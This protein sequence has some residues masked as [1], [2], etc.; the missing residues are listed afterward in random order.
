MVTNNPINLSQEGLAYYN[1]TGTFTGVDGSTT[2]FVCTSNGPGV[3]PT[4][5]SISAGA[6]IW[7]D[8][9]TSTNLVINSNY[10]ATA[11]VTL[12]L[13]ASPV[14]GSRIRVIVDTASSV[15]LQANTGQTIRLSS[16]TSTLAG[17]ITN[18]LRGD[19]VTLEYRSTGSVWIALSFI[20]AWTPA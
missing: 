15:V 5:Q 17:T 20:G 18:S 7:I 10:F 4:F 11:A 6:E 1:G 2:G 3:M 19:A 8:Q 14:Q 13:P 9:G 12:T 16:N